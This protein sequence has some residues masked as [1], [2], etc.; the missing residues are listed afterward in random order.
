VRSQGPEVRGFKGMRDGPGACNVA[1]HRARGGVR[2]LLPPAD[3]AAAAAAAASGGADLP[4][5]PREGQFYALVSAV[6]APPARDAAAALPRALLD[7]FARASAPRAPWARLRLH[8]RLTVDAGALGLGPAGQPLRVM[9]N[10]CSGVLLA[11]WDWRANGPALSCEPYGLRGWMNAG[12][13]C[14]VAIGRWPTGGRGRGWCRWRRGHFPPR[15]LRAR[16]WTRTWPPFCGSAAASCRR[17]RRTRRRRRR[18]QRRQKR[19]HRRRH[20]R[21]P[22]H[23][24]H[25]RAP[26]RRRPRPPRRRPPL[27]PRRPPRLLSPPRRPPRRPLQHRLLPRCRRVAPRPSFR[28]I[29]TPGA[30]RPKP[31]LGC[32]SCLPPIWSVLSC[33]SS[34]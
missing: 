22:R 2:T 33:P 24:R 23:P 34:L 10:A 32:A 28:P 27:R 3:A 17:T 30:P 13:S 20:P 8:V 14:S 1:A 18:H 21:H 19:R 6:A 15:C 11:V 29:G 26:R 25:R 7:A 31:R 16:R 4:V 12:F 5:E 9:G